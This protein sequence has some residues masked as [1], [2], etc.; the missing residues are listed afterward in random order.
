M[1]LFV[2]VGYVVVKGSGVFSSLTRVV[3]FF[4]VLCFV[5]VFCFV[6]LKKSFLFSFVGLFDW[7]V[8]FGG[9]VD[10]VFVFC[11]LLYLFFGGRR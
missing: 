7:V 2:G 9:A 11:L 6:H 1:F 5:V 4:V 8:F 10:V 3:L